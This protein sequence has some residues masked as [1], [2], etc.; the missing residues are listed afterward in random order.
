MYRCQ[1]RPVLI[2]MCCAIQRPPSTARL[3]HKAWPSVPPSITPI[4]S[5]TPTDTPTVTPR[6]THKHSR[7]PS[8]AVW[9]SSSMLVSINEVNLHR[10][11]LV[12]GW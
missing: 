7:R 5:C 2:E 8:V 12:L 11:R 4:T 9:R 3:V 6:Y 1:V 10:A